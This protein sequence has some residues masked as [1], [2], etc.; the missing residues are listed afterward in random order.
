MIEMYYVLIVSP[1]T[2]LQMVSDL[3]LN[4]DSF[5]F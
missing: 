2:I 3:N 4:F 5:I 1:T